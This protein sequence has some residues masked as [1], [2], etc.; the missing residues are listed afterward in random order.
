VATAVATWRCGASRSGLWLPAVWCA[1]LL[2]TAAAQ[3]LS[4]WHIGH[5]VVGASIAW[6][7]VPAVAAA[8]AS[9]DVTGIAAGSWWVLA[10]EGTAFFAYGLAE[11]VMASVLYGAIAVLGSGA[12]LVRVSRAST[13]PGP[14]SPASPVSCHGGSASPQPEPWLPS[15]HALSSVPDA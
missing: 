11:Q 12:I 15:R 7:V 9:R 10:A 2:A 5:L 14:V 4:G 13:F 6:T 1:A 3:T 8:W